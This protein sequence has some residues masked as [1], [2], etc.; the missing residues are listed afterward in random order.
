MKLDPNDLEAQ[1]YVLMDRLDHQEIIPFVR[2]YL[3]K[4]T[5]S[6]MGYTLVNVLILGLSLVLIWL[7]IDAGRFTIGELFTRIAYGM[8]I[9]FAL[10]P[11]HELIHGL[12]YKGQG[13]PRTSYAMNLRKFY[14][15]AVA[16]RFVANR[17]EFRIV[18]LAPFVT[19]TIIGLTVFALADL[20][21][22]LTVLGMLMTHTAFCSGDF[23]LLSYFEA[24]RH[25]E[26]VTYDDKA[27][28]L[29]FFYGRPA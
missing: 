25:R 15:L 22:R 19:V 6:A 3:R 20:P 27:S 2:E 29:T 24:N 28:G 5:W 21:L 7:A 12:A 1:G 23:G 4:P 11:V 13:A 14:F 10:I 26:P 16:D 17:R 8:A 18:A 9:A